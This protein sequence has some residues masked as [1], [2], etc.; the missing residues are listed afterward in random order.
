MSQ[1]DG[2]K[3]TKRGKSKVDEFELD[4]MEK[5]WECGVMRQKMGL[6][7]GKGAIRG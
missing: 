2:E 3:L 6:W 5:G 7:C 1:T 4:F